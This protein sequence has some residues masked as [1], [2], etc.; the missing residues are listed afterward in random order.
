[1]PAVYVGFTYLGQGAWSYL[2][3]D[4]L[5]PRTLYV[6]SPTLTPLKNIQRMKKLLYFFLL[7]FFVGCSEAPK[8]QQIVMEYLTYSDSIRRYKPLEW[9]KLDTV[10]SKVEDDPAYQVVR[11]EAVKY[12]M[13]G[14]EIEQELLSQGYLTRGRQAAWDI[15]RK[16][17][18]KYIHM[19]DS[20]VKH[21]V[22]HLTGYSIRHKYRAKKNTDN[23]VV[24]DEVFVLDSTLTKVVEVKKE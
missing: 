17:L 5:S 24:Y 16:W 10:Y 18:L 14:S 12:Y 13:A 9:G 11:D 20:I 22:P 7:F 21:Y 19:G 3:T 4:R 2:F 6:K 8:E 1:M 15:S 23:V